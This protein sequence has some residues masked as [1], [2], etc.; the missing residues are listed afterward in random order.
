MFSANGLHFRKEC[1][2]VEFGRRPLCRFSGNYPI[3]DIM[4]RRQVL[5]GEAKWGWEMGVQ[6][7]QETESPS[8]WPLRFKLVDRNSRNA[9]LIRSQ[10]VLRQSSLPQS[11]QTKYSSIQ[12]KVL[13]G[14]FSWRVSL[15]T[16]LSS[17]PQFM[18]RGSPGRRPNSRNT[19]FRL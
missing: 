5:T 10:C 18:Q 8:F 14:I 2:S 6:A 11:W 13:G 4:T 7:T 16:R 19:N 12:R 3:G 1:L 9:R 17:P 15:S